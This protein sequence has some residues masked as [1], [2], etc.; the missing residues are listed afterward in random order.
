MFR[1]MRTTVRLD[2]QLLA[3]AKKRAAETGR[4]LTSILEQA[5]RE[6]LQHQAARARAP[7]RKV[8]LKTVNGTGLRPGVDLDDSSELLDAME[9]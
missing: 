9:S 6:S 3:E 5:L 8:S 1:H 2:E 4:T 7:S